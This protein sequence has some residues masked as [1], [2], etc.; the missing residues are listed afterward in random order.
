[1]DPIS[2]SNNRIALAN[3]V[4]GVLVSS[5]L[6]FLAM[7][8]RHLPQAS[9]GGQAAQTAEVLPLLRDSG[10]GAAAAPAFNQS[11]LNT[12]V[13][14]DYIYGDPKARYSLITYL[15]FECPFCA[16]F[17]PAAK[18]FVDKNRSEVNLVMRMY[19]LEMH[20][21]ADLLTRYAVCA[22]AERPDSFV[23]FADRL[24]S[25]ERV[26]ENAHLLLDPIIAEL[27]LDSARLQTCVDAKQ[28]SSRIAASVSEGTAIGVLG[29]PSSVLLDHKANAAEFIAGFKETSALQDQLVAMRTQAA[30]RK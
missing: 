24:F 4:Q 11:K 18:A 10:A 22:A 13:K 6:V 9:G 8:L 14:N 29:T 2:K 25:A 16:R 23:K 7:Q 5:A 12:E 3:L 1:M 30:V 21:N 15:D 26:P 20:R 27:K 28:T 17:Y 19:P